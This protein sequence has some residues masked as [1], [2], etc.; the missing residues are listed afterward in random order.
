[1]NTKVLL[2]NQTILF[3]ALELLCAP[4][5]LQNEFEFLD[6]FLLLFLKI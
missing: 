1:M 6:S 2:E 3:L 4:I 5:R